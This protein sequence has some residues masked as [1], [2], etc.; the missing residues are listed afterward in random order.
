MNMIKTLKAGKK[1][2]KN[3]CV[4]VVKGDRFHMS[5]GEHA[6]SIDIDSSCERRLAAHW[7]GFVD[8]RGVVQAKAKKPKPKKVAR[9]YVVTFIVKGDTF[10]GVPRLELEK[11][12]ATSRDEA[13]AQAREV[14]RHAQGPWGLK[15][16]IRARRA[17]PYES[18][19]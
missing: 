9:V 13:I 11:L 14:W 18:F 17:T 1:I 8:I 5:M 19:L 7:E 4:L 15:C 16:T 12:I 10:T 3:G 2:E 6:H